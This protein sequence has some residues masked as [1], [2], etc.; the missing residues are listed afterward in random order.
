MISH[1]F[2]WQ[3]IKHTGLMRRFER[4]SGMNNAPHAVRHRR[5]LL[6][7]L[8]DYGDDV[9]F[10]RVRAFGARGGIEYNR[11]AFEVRM[12]REEAK[13][14][15]GEIPRDRCAGPGTHRGSHWR[16]SSKLP[17]GQALCGC[18]CARRFWTNIH[19][20][21]RRVVWLRAVRR[22]RRDWRGHQQW[23]AGAPVHRRC[24]CSGRGL[25]FAVALWELSAIVG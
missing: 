3:I 14:T 24:G 15:K 23:R 4:G 21:E 10:A 12:T 25:P 19:R 17:G 6:A 2:H 16:N 18:G 1:S 7:I 22:A 9:N 13:G 8:A 5:T 20:R 11:R